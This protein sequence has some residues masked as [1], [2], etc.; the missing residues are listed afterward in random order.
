M[1]HSGCAASVRGM[2]RPT[3]PIETDRLLLRAYTPDDLDALYD[4]RS[5]PDVVRYLLFDVRT[6]EQVRESLADRV[7]QWYLEKEG[8]AMVLAVQ[9]KDTGELIGDVVLFWRSETSGRG[10]LGF[11]F[12]PDHSGKGFASEAA[13]EV[14]RLGFE[15]LGLHRIEGRCDLRNTASSRLMERLGMRREAVFKEY[16]FV[17]G[18][19][20]DE[21]ILAM[22]D[23]EWKGK[24]A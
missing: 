23:R 10:E 3:L 21:L 4:I 9:R 16:E 8:D 12:H 5:R 11:V 22:L 13:R 2:L 24:Q 20:C 18:E 7:N 19:W 14:L 1:N 17:K 6:R 15:E